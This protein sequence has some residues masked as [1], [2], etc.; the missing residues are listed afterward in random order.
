MESNSSA[1][2]SVIHPPKETNL[3]A[4]G[5][6]VGRVADGH[7]VRDVEGVGVGPGHGR[8]RRLDGRARRRLGRPEEPRGGGV[9]VREDETG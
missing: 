2:H 9:V 1:P 8:R 3:D 5:A 6:H 7:L 4:L